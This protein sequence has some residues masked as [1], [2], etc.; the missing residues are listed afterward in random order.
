MKTDKRPGNKW[1]AAGGGL[2]IIIVIL[3]GIWIFKERKG[4]PGGEL[5]RYDYRDTRQL[6]ALTRRAATLVN[7]EGEKAFESFRKDP[8]RWSLDGNSYLYVYDMEGVN[9]F[10]GGYPELK[11][12]NLMELTD[13]DGKKPVNIIINQLEHHKDINPHG[14]I[15]YLWVPPGAIDPVWKSSCNFMATMPDRRRVF[16][17]SGID[18]PLQ[19]REFYRIIVD[20]AVELLKREGKA[21]LEMIKSP[22]SHFAIHDR[23]VFVI[24]RDGTAIVDPGLNLGTPR[25]LFEYQDPSGR[26][27]VVE[28]SKKLLT[29]D[30]G[31]VIMIHQ[32]KEGSKPIKNGIYGRRVKVDGED[33]IIGA[34]SPL[35]HPAWMR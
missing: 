15:H 3:A 22:E 10:H 20:E 30:T 9:L 12:K 25:N 11:G 13:L 4:T 7:V 34:I 19:E 2:A 27:P 23:G 21:G 29:N 35:P 31:W 17:G 16:V 26:R 14:W 24:T 1:L 6:V 28:L 32:K 8:K 5:H 18:S 33:L